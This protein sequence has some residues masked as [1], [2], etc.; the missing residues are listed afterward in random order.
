M[1]I[2]RLTDLFEINKFDIVYVFMWIAPFD[3]FFFDRL[4]RF[5]SKNLIYDI[6]DNI[7][8]RSSGSVNFI[9]W[10]LKSDIQTFLLDLA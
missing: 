2:K 6:E 5:L 7:L 10:L 8:E 9:S 3:V 1:N 4:V